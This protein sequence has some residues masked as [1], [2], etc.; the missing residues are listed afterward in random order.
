MNTETED[1]YSPKRLRD[2]EMIRDVVYKLCRAVDRRDTE[3]LR[4]AFHPDA[5]DNHGAKPW[6]VE[7]YVQFSKERN[8]LIPFSM[9]Q[10]GNVL[11][12]FASENVALVE[13]YIWNVTRFPAGDA[14]LFAHPAAGANLATLSAG[15]T[16]V[17]GAHRYVDRFERRGDWR[18]ARRV[19]VFEWRTYLPVPALMP[20]FPATATIG[21]R[22]SE[23]WLFKER[24]ELN[25]P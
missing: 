22:S 1:P 16:D 23:D 18:I 17:F 24:R 21:S 11:I 6:G 20:N 14:N 25:L 13:S 10:L 2:R 15:V 9:H 19:V 5:T 8:K 12:E 4:S 7:D 3:A